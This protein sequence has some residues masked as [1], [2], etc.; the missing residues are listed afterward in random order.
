M[1]KQINDNIRTNEQDDINLDSFQMAGGELGVENV[2]VVS[3][4]NFKYDVS[5]NASISTFSPTFL[6][7]Y[8]KYP[9]VLFTGEINS[10]APIGADIY[11]SE[12]SPTLL[13]SN[14]LT[15]VKNFATNFRQW[16]GSMC[17]RIIFT[18]PIFVQTK[19]IAA[20][21][22]GV[23]LD[24]AKNLTV[25]DLYG[26]QYHSVMNPDNDNELSF[27]IPFI[28]GL[29]WLN[30]E[31]STGVISIKLFQPLIASQPT[32]VSNV[33]IPYTILLSSQFHDTLNPLNFRFLISPSYN[34][35]IFK[36]NAN[37][38]IVNSISPVCNPSKVLP[39][40]IPNQQSTQF[41]SKSIVL[42]P[43]S[44]INNYAQQKYNHSIDGTKVTPIGNISDNVSSLSLDSN[45]VNV[46]DSNA[47]LYN[48]PF[49]QYQQF[50]LVD[51]QLTTR[52]PASYDTV[53][54][55]DIVLGQ[56]VINVQPGTNRHR[57]RLVSNIIN[58]PLGQFKVVPTCLILSTAGT[59]FY[60]YDI[61]MSISRASNGLYY[62]DISADSALARFPDTGS[63]EW[64]SSGNFAYYDSNAQIAPN[65]AAQLREFALSISA[66]A[67]NPN[68]TH[69]LMYSPFNAAETE[70]QISN[71]NLSN[72]TICTNDQFSAAANER[73]LTGYE[74]V[75]SGYETSFNT[76][77]NITILEI[78]YFIK[79][80]ADTIAVV[81]TTISNVLSYVLPSSII[82]NVN[83]NPNNF[84]ILPLNETNPVFYTP[85]GNFNSTLA[86]V[87]HPRI[88]IGVINNNVI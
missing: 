72:L 33:T 69:V 51:Q 23:T 68:S 3:N 74:I 13:K 34:N 66:D 62:H 64:A 49:S 85:T 73:S 67:P 41:S 7:N 80:A 5:K 26:A 83:V 58:S 47:L 28:T 65:V 14:S 63:V 81:S 84:I 52:V 76:S 59:S 17:L 78:L 6:S 2:N 87:N 22:P 18:K 44:S 36:S 20:F 32:G 37:A 9:T 25:Y 42:L 46:Y 39:G 29:N 54:T 31:Q 8:L 57:I 56:Y 43:R 1:E 15:R 88:R 71:N 30:M 35:A 24:Q 82:N 16:N 10:T 61:T 27:Y 45:K 77:P 60:M 19:V 12:I 21:L 48:T 11:T 86:P 70:Y 38:A 75:D 40:L 50:Q 55:T 53:F 4:N 79:A